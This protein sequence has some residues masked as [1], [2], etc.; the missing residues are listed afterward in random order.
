MK[1]FPYQV[2]YLFPILD[3]ICIFLLMQTGHLKI[4]LKCNLHYSI[5]VNLPFKLLC[6]SANVSRR[7][8]IKS[9]LKRII[10]Y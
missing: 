6:K 4:N 1:I 8:V 5:V 3:Y 10:Y 7:L 9:I 2:S